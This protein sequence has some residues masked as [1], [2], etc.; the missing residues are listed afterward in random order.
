MLGL[1]ALG[2]LGYWYLGLG[3]AELV[4]SEGGLG[5]VLRFFGQALS[6]ALSYEAEFVPAG[7]PPLRWNAVE[8]AGV[9]VVFAA[10]AMSLALVLGLVL[11]YN[12]QK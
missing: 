1:L 6:P 8:A 11:G 2:G 12:T 9:T 10:A 4:P 7:A 3:L 5:V